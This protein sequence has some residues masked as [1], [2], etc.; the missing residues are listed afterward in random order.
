MAAFLHRA[1]DL[2]ETDENFFIDDEN[3]VFED[4][5]NRLAAAGITRGCNPPTNDEFCPDDELTRAQMAVPGPGLQDHRRRRLRTCSSTTT[6]TSTN[7]R[8]TSS[9]R[10]E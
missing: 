3:V 10:R 4:E 2:P 7:G 9:A 1:L 5:I 8:S 6:A